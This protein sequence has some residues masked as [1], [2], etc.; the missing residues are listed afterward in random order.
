[1][2]NML[3]YALSLSVAPIGGLWDK[4]SDYE[5]DE[6]FRMAKCK[7]MPVQNFIGER[8][9][10]TAAEAAM[11]IIEELASL[12][13]EATHYWEED[14]PSILREIKRPPIVLYHYGPLPAK[15]VAVVGTR[16][17]SAY[18]LKVTEAIVRSLAEEGFCIVSGMAVGIDAAAHS[19]AL[20]CGGR[21]AGVLANGINVLYPAAN[22]DIYLG[23]SKSPGSCLVSEYPPGICAGRWTFVRRNRII[24]G[25][26]R[27]VVVVQAGAKSGTLITARYAAEQGREVYVCPGHAFDEGF[28]GCHRLLEQG[29][30]LCWNMDDFR[31]SI[32]G[33]CFDEKIAEDFDSALGA[34]ERRILKYL[35]DNPADIDTVIRECDIPAAEFHQA[36]VLLETEGIVER[37]G[38][39]LSAPTAR[40]NMKI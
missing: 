10:G 21:T 39:M 14:Y 16:R 22:R 24:S 34:T 30:N 17:P 33:L 6:L 27:A 5:P 36:L 31:E 35:S 7:T 23:I 13:I 38:N 18:S 37:K 3:E 1:M 19:A 28:A 20:G 15:A 11:A 40:T 8:Y 26:C 32:K 25:L 12:R 4:I 29:A 9:P 2:Y